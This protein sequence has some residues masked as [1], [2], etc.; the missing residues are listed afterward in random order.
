MGQRPHDRRNGRP[1][2]DERFT[3][4]APTTCL[5]AA[6]TGTRASYSYVPGRRT[7]RRSGRLASGRR[8]VPPDAPLR[9]PPARHPLRRRAGQP[10]AAAPTRSSTCSCRWPR[11][12][13]LPSR[14]PRRRRRRPATARA[15]AAPRRVGPAHREPVAEATLHAV[16]RG[17]R[18]ALGFENVVATAAEPDSGRLDARAAVGWN[19]DDDA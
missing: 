2:C 14:P 16:C 19:L 5:P 10:A 6:T 15:R 1:C 18:D 4:G 11:T 3:A 12:P 8:A 9:R 7:R 13:L 17:V